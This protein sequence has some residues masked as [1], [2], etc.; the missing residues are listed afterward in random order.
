MGSFY[1]NILDSITWPTEIP[2]NSGIC[3]SMG[4]VCP[5]NLPSMAIWRV[6]TVSLCP[7]TQSRSIACTLK[8]QEMWVVW[9]WDCEDLESEHYFQG[10]S[11]LSRKMALPR[12]KTQCTSRTIRT[13]ILETPPRPTK[14]FMWDLLWG[15]QEDGAKLRRKHSRGH[16]VSA[17][18][19]W[20]WLVANE[21]SVVLRTR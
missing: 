10:S 20:P 17:S 9:Q 14:A 7:L 3:N 15:T 19:L 5:G 4:C 12:V 18:L 11:S 1:P 8:T 2:S 6:Q 21:F 16:T 13:A